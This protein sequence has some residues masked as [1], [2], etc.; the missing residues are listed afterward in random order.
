MAQFVESIRLGFEGLLVQ[1]SHQ[2][3]NVVS[4]GMTLYLL[5]TNGSRYRPNLT[6]M[7]TMTLIINTSKQNQWM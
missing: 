3:H 4:V 6:K 1:D 5:L 2:I 7:L